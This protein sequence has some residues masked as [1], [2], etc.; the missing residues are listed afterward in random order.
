MAKM[1]ALK[2]PQAKTAVN[3]TE[4]IAAELTALLPVLLDRAFKGEL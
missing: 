1:D 4:E 3:K 2:R